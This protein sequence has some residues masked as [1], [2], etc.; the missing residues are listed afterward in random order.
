MSEILDRSSTPPIIVIQ[1]DE[2][3]YPNRLRAEGDDFDW[4]TATAAEVREK[5]G[6]LNAYFLP[7]SGRGRL[8][9]EITPVNSFRVVLNE[10]FGADLPL[11]P[12]RTIGHAS[13]GH[14]YDMFDLT[15]EARAPATA[16]AAPR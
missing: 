1:S 7:G 11:L 8:Y 10:Y 13:D 12:D 3:P 6:I 5:T 2:G 15:R 14:P 16:A 9:P 4:R